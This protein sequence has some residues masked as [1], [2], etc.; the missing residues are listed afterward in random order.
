MYQAE[1]DVGNKSVLENAVKELELRYRKI[2]ISLR[3]ASQQ[4]REQDIKV[5]FQHKSHYF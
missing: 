2:I 5:H 4:D 3:T 1:R